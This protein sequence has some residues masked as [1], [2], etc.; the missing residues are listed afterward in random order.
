MEEDLDDSQDV[1]GNFDTSHE[2]TMEE[3]PEGQQSMPEM[4]A[5][6]VH[7]EDDPEPEPANDEAEEPEDAQ[8][9][10]DEPEEEVSNHSSFVIILDQL[11]RSTVLKFNVDSSHALC[12]QPVNLSKLEVS[13]LTTGTGILMRSFR[14]IHPRYA[15]YFLDQSA[16]SEFE[17]RDVKPTSGPISCLG[18]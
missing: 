1:S 2:F 3:E 11:V 10:E 14:L 7:I 5:P 18:E 6:P 16:E 15:T 9:M 17:R 4:R 8:Q 12:A 13:G